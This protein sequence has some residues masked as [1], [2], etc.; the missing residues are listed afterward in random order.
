MIHRSFQEKEKISNKN[1]KPTIS[2][3]DKSIKSKI[4]LVDLAGFEN[5][6]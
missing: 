1:K 6:K 4:N 3:K 5:L 2:I